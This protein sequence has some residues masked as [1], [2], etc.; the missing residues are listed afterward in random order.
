[1]EI[2]W[3][4]CFIEEKKKQLSEYFGAGKILL[5]EQGVSMG[6]DDDVSMFFVSTVCLKL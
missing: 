2:N 1:M 5:V 4:I 6:E 3:I